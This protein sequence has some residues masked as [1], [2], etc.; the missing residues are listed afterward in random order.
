MIKSYISRMRQDATPS[1]FNSL[2]IPVLPSGLE[3]WAG[4]NINAI[5]LASIQRVIVSAALAVTGAFFTSE[6]Y[7]LCT[8]ASALAGRNCQP[9]SSG[10]LCT[11]PAPHV[12]TAKGNRAYLHINAIFNI[13]KV[14]IPADDP[15]GRS[16]RALIQ[17]PSRLGRQITTRPRLRRRRQIP[18]THIHITRPATP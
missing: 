18:V 6:N 1:A 3:I 14:I 8:A 5:D 2:A 10:R 4:R 13:G 9:T 17:M 12:D 7:A 16:I 11:L 15:Q